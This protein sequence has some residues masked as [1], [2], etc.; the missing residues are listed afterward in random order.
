M[1]L[2]LP[3]LK[4]L[5]ANPT[6]VAIAQ[7]VERLRTWFEGVRIAGGF[8]SNID[9]LGAIGE[10]IGGIVFDT[11]N[12][13]TDLVATGL[14]GK[15]MLQWAWVNY[16]GHSR[17]EIWRA[18]VDDLG[19]AVKVGDAWT[20]DVLFVDSS[21]PNSS[22]GA[23][24]F[25]WVRLVN[26]NDLAGAFNSAAGT[27]GSTADDPDYLIE[28]ATESKWKPN[29]NYALG[30]LTMPRVP[31]G[32]VYEVTVDVGSS[33]G[34]EPVWPVVID[35]TVVDGGLTWKCKSELSIESF[36]AIALVGGVPKLTLRE[37][38]IADQVV[39]RAKIKDLAVNDAKIENLSVAKLIAGIIQASNIFLGAE[40]RVHLDGQNNR[41]VVTD[42]GG[43]TRV[44]LGKLAGGYGIE[45][46]DAGGQM[47]LGSGGQYGSAIANS[48]VPVGGNELGNVFNAPVWTGWN[49]INGTG[50]SNIQFDTWPE[51]TV[52][53]APPHTGMIEQIGAVNAADYF[54]SNSIPVVPGE[55]YGFSIYSG[56]HRCNCDIF[57]RWFDSNSLFISDA[58][59]S[60][61]YNEMQ[62]GASLDTFKRL[63]SYGVAPVNAR[64][65]QL[66]IHKRGTLSD[67]SSYFFF[68]R[69]MFGRIG[70]G[71]TVAPPWT[72]GPQIPN[73]GLFATAPQLNSGNISTYIADLAVNTLQLAGN[74]VTVAD[75]TYA[76]D[77]IT[78]TYAGVWENTNMVLGITIEAGNAHPVLIMGYIQGVTDVGSGVAYSTIVTA[79]LI[80]D[81]AVV[82]GEHKTISF[83][84]SYNLGNSNYLEERHS[85][86]YKDSPGVGYHQY[87]IQVLCSRNNTADS[88]AKYGARSL[89]LLGA[90]K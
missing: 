61:N 23:T 50:Q 51:W 71:Q 66:F 88:F 27:P 60:V 83:M 62:G 4:R 72:P 38:F 33:S 3:V 22:L 36:F 26:K 65:A 54:Y 40:S 63:F 32:Y 89:V 9:I 8:Q 6:P 18:Q 47:I 74:S 12:V 76:T 15:I 28:L 82:I 44:V 37:I 85:F 30:D 19:Q 48:A 84:A 56:A 77:V 52:Q 39:S 81:D 21:L 2:K 7:E 70:D 59:W 90:K 45:I 35:D 41:L 43:V 87:V 49:F 34:A 80:R 58:P 42:A 57:I 68:T 79:R 53:P 11:P 20:P 55:T 13:P 31:N 64:Y 69:P 29:H 24:Y 67:S 16:N 14:F 46:Y 10:A 25:Y 78:P 17:T 73:Q 1:S 75:G 86:N 5:G